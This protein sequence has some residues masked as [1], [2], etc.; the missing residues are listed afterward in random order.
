MINNRQHHLNA[1]IAYHLQRLCGYAVDGDCVHNAHPPRSLWKH[2]AS[3]ASTPLLE[4][5]PVRQAKPAHGGSR[6]TPSILI[7]MP[8]RKRWIDI[9]RCFKAACSLVRWDFDR[10]SGSQEGYAT[11]LYVSVS[12]LFLAIELGRDCLTKNFDVCFFDVRWTCKRE[13]RHLWPC[14][15]GRIEV[16]IRTLCTQLGATDLGDQY[17]R[18]GPFMRKL[19]E[20]S[21]Y[22]IRKGVGDLFHNGRCRHQAYNAGGFM[23]PDRAFPRAK[24]LRSERDESMKV[25]QEPWQRPLRVSHH[26]VN[27]RGHRTDCMHLE[28]VA[29]G[30]DRER[31]DDQLGDRGVRA[32]QQMATEGAACD[33]IG[34]SGDNRTRVAHGQT[35]LLPSCLDL[36]RAIS[37]YWVAYRWRLQLLAMTPSGCHGRASVPNVGGSMM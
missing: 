15:V 6:A 14:V 28:A 37:W 12:R 2:N 26:K 35:P 34:R 29:I 3:N 10:A 31:V 11:A 13:C 23:V 30:R 5:I 27:M 22:W 7:P 16:H 1:T 9:V 18:P 8:N 36:M 20:A 33:E 19:H 32:Q 17:L 21:S 24:N 4:G 25:M